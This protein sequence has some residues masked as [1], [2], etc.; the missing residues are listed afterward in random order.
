MKHKEQLQKL[1]DI[2]D[3]LTGDNPTPPE[4]LE[5]IKDCITTLDDLLTNGNQR[6]IDVLLDFRN[7]FMSGKDNFETFIKKQEIK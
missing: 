3:S 7:E 2:K 5:I 1:T 4:V 6:D